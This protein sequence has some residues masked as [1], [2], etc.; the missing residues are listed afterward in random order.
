MTRS[1]RAVPA[2]LRRT[3]VRPALIERLLARFHDVARRIEIRLADFQVNDVPPL[4]FQRP[5]A[6]QYFEGGFGAYA[7]HPLS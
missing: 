7:A 4:G 5:G 1:P 2:A 6:Y 3:V